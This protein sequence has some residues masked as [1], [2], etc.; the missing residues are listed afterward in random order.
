MDARGVLEHLAQ[1]GTPAS[2]VARL[3]DVGSEPYLAYFEEELLAG[4]VSRGAAACRLY[5]GEYG[6][7]K[8]H[9]LQLIG[10]T[11]LARGAA[12][13]TSDLSQSLHLGDWRMLLEHVLQNVE[14]A[15]GAGV[16][17]RGLP[18]ILSDFIWDDDELD[19]V[20]QAR[21]P[22]SGFR[23]AIAQVAAGGL[24]DHELTAL[25]RFLLGESVT[26]SYLRRSGVSGIK[27]AVTDRNAER[28]LQTLGICLSAL[29]VSAL[30][31]LFDETEHTLSQRPGQREIR[32]ANLMRRIVDGAISGRLHGMF[33]AFAVLPGTIEQAS[34]VYPALGQRIGT[35]ERSPGGFRRPV[36]QVSQLSASPGP[37]EFLEMAVQRICRLALEIGE[38]PD[39]LPDTLRRAGRSVLDSYASG[40][41]RPLLK[42]LAVQAVTSV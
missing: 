2:G 29:G 41:R 28:V 19:N 12:V 38:P 37:E 11:A 31:V 8:T 3:I 39:D 20:R 27:G 13:V 42:Q 23:D 7:G 10:E 32:A 14:L 33:F 4:F 21:V 5:E 25:H 18:N 16:R 17:H 9:I 26:I 30:V 36:L 15:D 35:L 24:P 22:H 1:H 40:Y 6:A 34:L